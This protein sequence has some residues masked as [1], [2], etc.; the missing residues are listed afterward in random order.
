MGGGDIEGRKK[1]PMYNSGG[2]FLI[3][4]IGESRRK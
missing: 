1:A 3:L 4:E 2:V